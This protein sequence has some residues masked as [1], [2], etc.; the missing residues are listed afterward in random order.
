MKESAPFR[1]GV[2]TRGWRWG[3]VSDRESVHG[4]LDFLGA[5]LRSATLVGVGLDAGEGGWPTKNQ[6]GD[7]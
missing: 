5:G 1:E 3:S 2:S 6:E 4:D 7:Q